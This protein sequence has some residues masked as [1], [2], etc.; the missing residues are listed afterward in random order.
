MKKILVSPSSFGECGNEPLEILMRNNF[1]IIRNPFGKKLT[2][3]EVMDLGREC[4]GIVAGVEPFTKKVIDALSDLKC[5]SRVGIGL[6]NIDLEY[7]KRKGIVIKN[8]P[9]GPSQS[10]A[11]LTVGLVF[12]IIR[13]ISLADQNIRRGIWRKE[14]GNLVQDK[15]IGILGL[16]RIGKLVAKM[17]LAL[18]NQVYAFDLVE[19]QEWLRKNYVKMV[20]KETLFK[21][22][23][24][25]TI[26]VPGNKDGSPII[27]K[28]E[29][30]LMKDSA[31][32]INISRGGV[33]DEEALF[34]YLKT[35]IICGAAIDVFKEEPYE[36]NLTKLDNVVLTPHLGS[37]AKESKLKMEIEAV[38]N[39]IDALAQ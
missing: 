30:K 16:G 32:L 38:M 33:V 18:E 39:L 2:E 36:G 35:K 25:I 19:D 20:K 28:E 22:A 3:E 31:Y 14:I 5:I 7:A 13:S 17:F 11:E 9:D 23:D 15:I 1:D 6:D 26:H 8:T 27:T 29:L 4:V 24:I 37:Y 21:E 12:N 34:H 10:V